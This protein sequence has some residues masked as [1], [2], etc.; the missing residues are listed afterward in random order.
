MSYANGAHLKQDKDE[1]GAEERG[2]EREREKAG[3]ERGAM[4]TM[5]H[6]RHRLKI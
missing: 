3:N 1:K 4:Q 6:K 2:G 5:N